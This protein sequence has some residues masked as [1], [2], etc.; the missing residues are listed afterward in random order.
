MYYTLLVEVC[1]G[2]SPQN[3]FKDGDTSTYG[4]YTYKAN[5]EKGGHV[6]V[7]FA[8]FHAPILAPYP[9]QYKPNG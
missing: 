2:D 6:E 1:Q 8:F 3:G 4:A 9:F 7:E 5:Q